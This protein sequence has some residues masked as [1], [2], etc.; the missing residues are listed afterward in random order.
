MNPGPES[1]PRPHT[2]A[3]GRLIALTVHLHLMVTSNL[4]IEK[5]SGDFWDGLSF[6]F[7]TDIGLLLIIV[8]K[9]SQL[10]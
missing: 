5:G 2:P 7:H 10:L 6:L 1:F 3:H 4:F 8:Q 9:L